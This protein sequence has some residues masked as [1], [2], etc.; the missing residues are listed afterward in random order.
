MNINFNRI[1][2]NES[3][4]GFGAQGAYMPLTGNQYG[5]VFVSVTT[6]DGFEIDGINLAAA[7]VSFDLDAFNAIVTGSVPLLFNAADSLWYESQMLA[8]DSN[9]QAAAQNG[10]QGVVAR[11]QA[12]NGTTFDRV[13]SQG[14]NADGVTTNA[15]G[16]L[17]V[18]SHGYLFNGSAWDR[19]RGNNVNKTVLVTAAGDTTIWDPA[20]GKR[21]RLMGLSISASGTA[22]ALV[23]DLLKLTDGTGG[24]VVWQGY[25]AVNT[26]VTGDTQISANFG[27]GILLTADNNLVAN[28]AT[29]FASG[30]AAVNAWGTEE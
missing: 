20:A 18:A 3:F 24:T 25:I 5:A 17:A 21:V 29:A 7:T 1:L 11:L 19:A 13:R 27:N 16:H 12:Y 8:T 10:L 4:A 26:T 14:D 6:R 9:G 28:L 30:G 22:A 2:N 15:N 23:A